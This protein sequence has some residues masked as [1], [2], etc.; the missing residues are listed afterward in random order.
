[1]I[2]DNGKEKLDETYEEFNQITYEISRES[3]DSYISY[4]AQTGNL[5]VEWPKLLRILEV[6]INVVS[7]LLL[8]Q[9][10]N[11]MNSKY[12]ELTNKSVEFNNQLNIIITNLKKFKL[13]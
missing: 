13:K 8:E 9:E 7:D 11:Q 2:K 10:L 3:F 5:N 1:M 6:K 12:P 4:T